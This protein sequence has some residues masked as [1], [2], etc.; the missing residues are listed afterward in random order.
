MTGAAVQ[1]GT[2]RQS[3]AIMAAVDEHA[4]NGADCDCG[5]CH[6][7]APSQLAIAS[8]NPPLSDQPA[9]HPGIAPT[10]TRAPLV[11]PPQRVA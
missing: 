3:S 11:P 9:H 1:A 4:G 2:E 10:T 8:P 6:A 7:P 5:S